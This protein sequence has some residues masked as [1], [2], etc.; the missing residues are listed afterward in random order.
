MSNKPN[1]LNVLFKAEPKLS[2][3]YNKKWSL[4]KT[5]LNKKQTLDLNPQ[6]HE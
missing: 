1:K 3:K 4:I 5:L 2:S 6:I